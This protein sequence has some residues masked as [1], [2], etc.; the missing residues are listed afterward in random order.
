MCYKPVPGAFQGFTQS[1]DRDVRGHPV[2]YK[3]R[4]GL[5]DRRRAE[6]TSRG[7]GGLLFGFFHSSNYCVIIFQC[8]L[9]RLLWKVC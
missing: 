3:A 8:V 7:R 2:I 5:T 4:V 6:E 9:D 1:S